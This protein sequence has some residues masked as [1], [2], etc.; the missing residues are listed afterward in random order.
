MAEDDYTDN[1]VKIDYVP[2]KPYV[3]DVVTLGV[4]Q[5]TDVV[6]NATGKSTDSVF[7][8]SHISEICTNGTQPLALAA[9]FYEDANRTAIPTSNPTEYDDSICGNVSSPIIK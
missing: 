7:M 2:V 3:T 4:G 9:I 6:V 5:R 1:S 8:R